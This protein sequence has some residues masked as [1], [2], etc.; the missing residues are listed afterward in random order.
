MKQHGYSWNSVMKFAEDYGCIGTYFMPT[1][2]DAYRGKISRG[3]QIQAPKVLPGISSL[4][5]S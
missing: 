1:D 4:I 3:R 5:F 2:S